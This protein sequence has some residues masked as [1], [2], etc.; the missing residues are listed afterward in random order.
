[1]PNAER[2]EKWKG[3]A[4]VYAAV[5]INAVLMMVLLWLF[6]ELLTP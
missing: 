1:M 3:W 2:N 6:S 5:I 4:W